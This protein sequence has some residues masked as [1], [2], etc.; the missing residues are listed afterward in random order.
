MRIR[1]L[2]IDRFRGINSLEF[3]PG[4]RT[5]ILGAN[6]AGKS[7]IL[8]ALDLLLHPGIGRARPGPTEIDY[9]NRD[10][11]AGFAIEAVIGDLSPSFTADVREHL[12][13]WRHDQREVVPET[14]GE[15]IEPVVRVRARGTPDLEVLHEFSKPESEGARFNPRVRQELGWIFD[16][17]LREPAQ[18]LAFYQG[19][20]LDRLFADTDLDPAITGLREALADGADAVNQETAIAAV[21]GELSQDLRRLGLISGDESPMF[22]VGAISRREL[23]QGLRLALLSNGVRIP[24]GR[25]GRGAQRLLLVAVLLRLARAAGRIPIGG[26]E[27]PEEAL[28][29]LRQSQL[30]QMLR[31]IA[32]TGGQVFV[33]SHSPEIARAFDIT[34]FLILRERDG[35]VNAR[36]LSRDLPP[37]ARQ[38]YE[39][40]VDG[41][42]VRGLFARIP[43]LVEGPG[44]RAALHVFWSALEHGGF[45]ASAQLGLDIVNA[46][47]APNMPM[48]VAVLSAA[49]RTVV[50]WLDQD[51][52]NVLATTQRLRDEQHCS[53]LVLHSQTPNINNLEGALAFGTSLR[54]LAAGLAVIASD[55]GY[56]WEAQRT[57]LLSR[58]Q[59][60][61]ADIRQQLNRTTSLLE[62]LALLDPTPARIL[63]AGAL[64][65]KAVT[66]FEIKGGRQARLFAE[67]IVQHDGVPPVYARALAQLRDWIDTGCPPGLDI[68]LTVD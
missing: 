39:R 26:F 16:G 18:Q 68:P 29:P 12:E 8:E 23:L 48:L 57:D 50:A 63:I 61:A 60:V 34:D 38:A 56:T 36:H 7:A 30:A 21:L 41:A 64:S 54:A 49:G 33:V 20:L 37:A 4:P 66:P 47:G 43:L 52:P 17:R 11:N 2:A 51:D 58:L 53:A 3:T 42:L 35:G 31:S 10:V 67:T 45:P 59:G 62:L 25:Q 19:G 1:R 27:E 40:W 14:N 46:E 6:N 15:G 44:D 24:L 32:D 65:A 9:F 28:E 22:E 55:R 13:G 5:L